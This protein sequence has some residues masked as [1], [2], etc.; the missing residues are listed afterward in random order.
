MSPSHQHVRALRE[1]Y[2]E[3]RRLREQDA[4]G[5]CADPKPDMAALAQRFPG[6][7]RELDRLPMP[8]LA[9]RLCALDA[10]L[11][12]GAPVPDWV[13]LQI[14]YHGCMR[15][16]LRVKRWFA[17]RSPADAAA[18]LAELPARYQPA[19]DEPP[20]ASF[21]LAAVA[22]I[23]APAGG[24]LN[25]WVYARVAALHGVPPEAVRRAFFPE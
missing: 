17:G 9:Q 16:V 2:R 14:G 24:R 6:A 13:P 11:E 10:V 18:V 4:A 20:L 3:I 21:D 1:K 22:A 15:A 8:E 19:P 7:L 23:L 25:P 12:R 5:S